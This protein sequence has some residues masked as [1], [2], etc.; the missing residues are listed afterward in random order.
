MGG[1]P[2]IAVS[3]LAGRPQRSA[4]ASTAGKQPIEDA[5]EAEDGDSENLFVA[6]QGMTTYRTDRSVST[7]RLLTPKR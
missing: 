4:A 6:V 1:R 2:S 7:A 5:K 3:G